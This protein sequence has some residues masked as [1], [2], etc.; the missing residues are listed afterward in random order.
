[1]NRFLVA[2]ITIASVVTT[3]ALASLT[4]SISGD[5]DSELHARAGR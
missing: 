3:S 2:A 5:H 1:M 4:M